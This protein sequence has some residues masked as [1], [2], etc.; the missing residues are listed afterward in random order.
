MRILAIKDVIRKD[1]PIYYRRF[2]SGVASIEF[3][4]NTMDRRIDFFIETLPTGH[5]QIIVT[6]AEPVDYPLVPLIKAL[7]TTIDALDTDGKL[8]L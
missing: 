2:F 3:L 1:T 8:P 7:K 5:K 6:L 4:S